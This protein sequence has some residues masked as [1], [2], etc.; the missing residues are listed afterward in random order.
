LNDF[1]K[2]ECY[3]GPLKLEGAGNDTFL[4][5]VFHKDMNRK[6]QFRLKNANES[7]TR[8]WRYHHYRSGLDY[9]TKRAILMSTLRKVD[10]MASN[11]EQLQI[12][13]RAKCIEFLKLGYPKGIL[14]YMCSIMARDTAHKT[15]LS[16][17]NDLFV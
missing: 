12:S 17:T 14:K 8:V 16:G 2:S 7:E 15:W 6:I 10:R 3:W 9:T 5:N 1:K 11:A 13:V 4:E